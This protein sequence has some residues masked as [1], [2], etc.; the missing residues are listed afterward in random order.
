MTN[1]RAIF[2]NANVSFFTVKDYFFLAKKHINGNIWL[3]RLLIYL[4]LGYDEVLTLQ[5]C[6]DNKDIDGR[7]GCMSDAECLQNAKS[8]CDTDPNCFGVSWLSAHLGQ[9]LKICL[10]KQMVPK[11]DGWRTMMKLS[12]GKQTIWEIFLEYSY[13]LRNT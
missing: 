2:A 3:L 11:T 10:S 13:I 9:A 4:H 8:Q 12:T 7:E 6:K 1:W 5:W